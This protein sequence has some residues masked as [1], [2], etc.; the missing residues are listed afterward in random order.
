MDTS[1]NDSGGG[2]PV[3]RFSTDT[4]APHE[5]AAAWCEAY[6]QT[7]AKLELDPLPEGS[8][9]AE[10]TLRTLPGLGIVS[11]QTGRMN[12]RCIFHAD[13]LALVTV[14]SG[15]WVGTQRGREVALQAGEST[16]CMNDEAMVGTA[17]GRRSIV[18]IPLKAVQPLIGAAKLNLLKPLPANT[19]TLQLLGYYL[20]AIRDDAAA[21]VLQHVAVSHV[22]DLMALLVGATREGAEVAGARGVA[23][24]RLKAIKDDVVRNLAEGDVSV[25]AI[26]LRHRVTPRYIQM[27]FEN[28]GVTFTEYVRGERLARAHRMLTAPRYAREKISTIAYGCGFGDLSYF[29]RLFRQC[30]GLS[31]SDVRAAARAN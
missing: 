19:A 10:A 4:F 9:A 15:T 22:H 1:V 2:A 25:G 13:D 30:Y 31:A 8:F 21:P 6:G 16:L 5:R 17:T 14:E 20:R 12:W 27:L 3:M 29:N 11:T 23:A 7:I 24:A 26:A 28:E 18:C